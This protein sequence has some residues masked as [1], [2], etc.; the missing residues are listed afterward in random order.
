MGFR[1]VESI[2]SSL[3]LLIGARKR[4]SRPKIDRRRIH[5]EQLET[6]N[7]MAVVWANMGSST[8]DSDLFNAYF[9]ANAPLA[10]SIV[11]EAISDWNRIVIGSP[12]NL[13]VRFSAA[14]LSGTT[15]GDTVITSISAQGIPLAANIRLD[16]NAA[17]G[18]WFFD[19]TP[20]NDSEFSSL[21]TPFAGSN[22]SSS[23]DLYTT[24]AHEIGHALGFAVG[25]PGLRINTFLSTP[26]NGRVNFYNGAGAYKI[27]ATLDTTGHSL[28]ANDLMAASQSLGKRQLISNQAAQIL[29]DAYGYTISLPSNTDTLHVNFDGNLLTTVVGAAGNYADTVVVDKISSPW[30]PQIRIQVNGTSELAPGEYGT[31]FM[32]STGDGTTR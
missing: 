4:T 22:G 12:N 10:R 27:Q 28:D 8:N 5:L 13:S 2:K 6:R 30:P 18:T 1:I 19:P 15:L 24:V 29:A 16:N 23:V 32:L 26:V 21:Q 11:R 7:L 20:A 17:G 31:S 25:A 14:A 9:G 3:Q